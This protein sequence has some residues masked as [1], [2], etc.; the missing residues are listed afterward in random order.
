V[1]GWQRPCYL[2]VDE[3]YAPTF[4]ALIEETNWDRYGTGYNPKCANCMAHCGYESTAVNDAINHPLKA[5]RVFLRGPKTEGPFAPELPI[6][7]SI[8]RPGSG[9]S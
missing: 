8:D 3:G 5:L 2:L 9:H 7:Y 1:F 4:K 6:T